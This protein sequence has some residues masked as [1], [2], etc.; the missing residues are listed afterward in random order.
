MRGVAQSQNEVNQSGGINGKLLQVEIA[1]DDNQP[2]IAARDVAPKLVEDRQ[3]LAV[4]GHNASEVSISAAPVYQKG[5]LAIIS[6]TSSAMELSGIGNHIFRTVP[7]EQVDAHN[8]AQYAIK[9]AG[10]N[11]FAICADSKSPY[12]K[13]IE[14]EFSSA[15]QQEGGQVSHISCDF[16]TPKFNPSDFVGHAIA[17]GVDSLL[18]APSVERIYHAIDVAKASKGKL[19]LFGCSPMYTHQTL[20]LGQVNVNG[21]VLAVIWH[22]AAI[23]GNPFPNRAA[24]LWGGAVSWRTAMSY[25][26]TQAIVTGLKQSSTRNGL[27]KVLS[28]SGFT[29][30][31]ATGK[32]QFLPSGDR[33]RIPDIGFLVRVQPVQGSEVGYDFVPV[34]P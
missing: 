27:Q 1:N 10:R 33:K 17:D 14:R 31:G 22:P 6:P 8:L 28:N 19:T 26:A 23:P 32:V 7:T 11:K 25:D 2:E 34:Q 20:K 16:S 3:I 29:A 18:L 5:G 15:V 12:S 13:S 9:K 4:V 24:K 21:M 30:E